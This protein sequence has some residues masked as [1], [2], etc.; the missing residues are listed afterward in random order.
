M[1]MTEKAAGITDWTIDSGHSTCEFTLRHVLVS[2]IKGAFAR[3]SGQVHFEPDAVVNSWVRAEIDV[4]S[5][6]THSPSRDDM[7][8]GPDQFDVA[9]YPTASFAS[10]Q[11]NAAD[12]RHFQV[13]GDLTFRGV[14]QPVTFDTTFEGTAEQA[15]GIPRAAFI[16]RAT[17]KRTDFGLPLGRMIPAGVPSI[18]DEI[19]LAM[20]LTCQPLEQG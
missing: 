14:S 18:L 10:N 17:I 15:N 1:T 7:L 6:D 16:A 2:T 11:V 3:V 9:T 8:R 19:Q 20:Y 12:D 5:V 13:S 4:A